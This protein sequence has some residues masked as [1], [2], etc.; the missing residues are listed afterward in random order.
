MTAR[1]NAEWTFVLDALSRIASNPAESKA[2][3]RK[4]FNALHEL[5]RGSGPLASTLGVR[6]SLSPV[7][8]GNHRGN[9]FAANDIEYEG[10]NAPVR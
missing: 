1:S 9:S 6:V 4:A 8:V 7:V 10:G 3:R 5:T 2:R